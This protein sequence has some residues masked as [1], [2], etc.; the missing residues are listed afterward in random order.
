MRSSGVVLQLPFV[1]FHEKKEWQKKSLGT[2]FA[3]H[4]LCQ[5]NAI[6]VQFKQIILKMSDEHM[7]DM[8]IIKKAQEL[9]AEAERKAKLILANAE[10]EAQT[11][12]DAAKQTE[13]KAQ[14]KLDAAKQT[15]V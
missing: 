8:L 4:L 13:Q 3:Y 10:S 12:L 7:Q 15:V 9:L 6:N 2:I 14:A 11:K 1:M 5:K